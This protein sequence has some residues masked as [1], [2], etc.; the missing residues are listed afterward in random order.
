M[1]S[2][3]RRPCGDEFREATLGD[4]FREVPPVDEFGEATLEE[5]FSEV[6]PVEEHVY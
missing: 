1:T 6:P 5:E 2:S 4:K 3:G